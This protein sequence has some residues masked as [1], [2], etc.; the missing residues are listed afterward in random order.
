[1]NTV[2]LTKKLWMKTLLNFDHNN[3]E[4]SNYA[5]IFDEFEFYS[6]HILNYHA[7]WKLISKYG[8]IVLSGP[9]KGLRFPIPEVITDIPQLLGK[10]GGAAFISKYLLGT[11]ES[12]LHAPIHRISGNQYECVVDLGCSLGYYA[13]GFAKIFESAEIFAFDANPGIKQKL[14]ELILLNDFSS[15]IKIGD[16][17][18]HEHF[19]LTAGKKSLVFCDIEGAELDLLDPSKNNEIKKCDFIIELHDVFNPSISKEIVTRFSTTHEIEIF[20]NNQYKF[21]LPPEASILTDLELAAVLNE[22]RGGPTPWALL[23]SK[24][25]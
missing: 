7:Q 4:N 19:N 21:N 9:F 3:F 5:G 11:Y 14:S 8:P 23:T 16:L 25:N 6:Y 20:R 18:T 10:D 22:M 1:M 24:S 15:R 12:E 17:W 13:A 2:E